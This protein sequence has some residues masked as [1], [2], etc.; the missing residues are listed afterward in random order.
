MKH[1][2]INQ[3]REFGYLQ[4]VAVSNETE[5]KAEVEKR[6]EDWKRGIWQYMAD[7]TTPHKRGHVIRFIVK[8]EKDFWWRVDS[9]KN[10]TYKRNN[11]DA[12][13]RRVEGIIWGV[14]KRSQVDRALSDAKKEA[15]FYV[16]A[17]LHLRHVINQ[18]AEKYGE[19]RAGQYP[20]FEKIS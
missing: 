12:V 17:L 5:I 1:T 14:G 3:F 13:A 2:H 16:R 10:G 20:L 9:R 15:A 19:K 11:P 7:H 6:L 8:S 18:W 4:D